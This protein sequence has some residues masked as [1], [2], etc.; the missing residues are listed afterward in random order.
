VKCH[1]GLVG[2]D[3]GRSEGFTVMVKIPIVTLS[4]TKVSPRPAGLAW[5]ENLEKRHM[6]QSK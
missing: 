1:D 5:Q 6:K 4:G 2:Q 3:A